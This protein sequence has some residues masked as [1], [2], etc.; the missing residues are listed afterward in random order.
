M[1]IGIAE[2]KQEQAE[3]KMFQEEIA[4]GKKFAS[5]TQTFNYSI[6]LNQDRDFLNP[7]MNKEIYSRYFN[8]NFSI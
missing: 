4:S 8:S 5:N 7:S 2:S 3:F 1:R 6:Y